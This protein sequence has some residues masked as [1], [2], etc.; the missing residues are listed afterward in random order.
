[1]LRYLRLKESISLQLPDDNW[2][3]HEDDVLVI[4]K[5]GVKVTTMNISGSINRTI[6][7]SWRLNE[8]RYNKLIDFI[9]EPKKYELEILKPNIIDTKFQGKN[10]LWV[11]LSSSDSYNNIF[12]DVTIQYLREDKIKSLIN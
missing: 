6:S 3:F 8:V 7:E 1:M 11:P 9:S 12:E 4:E 5:I 10:T 2:A